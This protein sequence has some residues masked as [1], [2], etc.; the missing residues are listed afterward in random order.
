MDRDREPGTAEHVAPAMTGQLPFGIT[1]CGFAELSGYCR[2]EVSHVLSIL[3]P[4]APVPEELGSLADHQRLVLRFHDVIENVSGTEP[5]G[6][7][8]I[9]RL[10]AFGRK[11]ATVRSGNPHL[12][13]HCHAGFSRSPAALTLLLAQTRPSR[14]AEPLATD[15][16]RIRPNAWPN[17]RIIELGDQILQ[18][19][20]E[21]VE[22]AF[23]IYR[24]RLEQQA[25]LAELM[26][27]NGRRREVEAGRRRSEGGHRHHS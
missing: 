12:L 9:R 10:L 2:A 17:L 26:V 21:I 16:L 11:L 14:R 18:R 5:P 1:V 3:D 25:G 27:A 24:R 4:G 13:I 20:G 8:H 23:E 7:E 6:P 15:V 19:R 22:A